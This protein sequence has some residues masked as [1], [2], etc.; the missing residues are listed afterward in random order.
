MSDDTVSNQRSLPDPEACRT[1]YRGQ[2]LDLSKCLVENPAGCEFALRF[3][4]GVSCYHPDRR[5][6]EK[7][8]SPLMP[9]LLH[10]GRDRQ[11]LQQAGHSTGSVEM[12]MLFLFDI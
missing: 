7:T 2:S 5:R 11:R 12:D 4:S 8:N 10:R 1:R 3:G 9:F 6:F